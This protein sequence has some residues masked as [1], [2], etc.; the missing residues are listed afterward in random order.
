MHLRGVV[1]FQVKMINFVQLNYSMQTQS[2]FLDI[3]LFKIKKKYNWCRWRLVRWL[4]EDFI[5]MQIG[6]DSADVR[7]KIYY[8]FVVNFFLLCAIHVYCGVNIYVYF[9]NFLN[10]MDNWLYGVFVTQHINML[11]FETSY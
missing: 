6:C 11:S 1:K 10:K 8:L 4:N 7:S 5:F 9:F 3:I 2:H